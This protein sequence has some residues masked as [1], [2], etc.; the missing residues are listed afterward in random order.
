MA[1]GGI[2][3]CMPAATSSGPTMTPSDV[4]SRNM[5]PTRN[6]RLATSRNVHFDSNPPNHWSSPAA[7]PLAVISQLSAAA[8]DRMIITLAVVSA[9]SRNT[10]TSLLRSSS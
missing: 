4:A 7:T 5:P 3:Y 10:R 1:T 6:T 8:A 9:P 2:P